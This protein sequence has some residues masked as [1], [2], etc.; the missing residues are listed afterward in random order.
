MVVL[1]IAFMVVSMVVSMVCV[2]VDDGDGVSSGRGCA[3]E[4]TR[5][6]S[7]MVK[8]EK[9]GSQLQMK[10]RRRRRRINE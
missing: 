10:R 7:G 2:R 8:G 1:V 9:L 6:A 5:E 3:L 4:L